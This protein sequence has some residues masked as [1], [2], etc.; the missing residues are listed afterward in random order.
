MAGLSSFDR[1][2]VERFL[3]DW[4]E[5]FDEGRY[6]RM[7]EYYA[8]DARLVATGTPTLRGRADIERFFRAACERGRAI[9]MRRTIQLEQ[10]ET[11]GDV[12]YMRGTVTLSGSNAP[13]PTTVRY[14]TL[15]KRQADG[16]W[17]LIED[18]SCATPSAAWPAP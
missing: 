12:G 18:I 5:W 7:T 3:H 10:A 6:Q 1:D 2:D 8:E 15:W 11:I 17:R 4:V 16:A 9:G 14:T 13:E